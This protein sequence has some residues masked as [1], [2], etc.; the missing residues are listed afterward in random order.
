MRAT[1]EDGS[2]ATPEARVVVELPCGVILPGPGGP[3][4][5]RAFKVDSCRVLMSHEPFGW[6][7]SVS[8]DEGRYPTWDELR[9]IAWRLRPGLAFTL[10]IPPQDDGDYV[11]LHD[12]VLHLWEAK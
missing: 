5:V 6:H 3:I 1:N 2:P 9:D 11:N 4:S 10:D 8:T 12:R 7:L